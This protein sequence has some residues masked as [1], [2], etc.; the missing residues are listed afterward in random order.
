MTDTSRLH[1][2]FNGQFNEEFRSYTYICAMD[3]GEELTRYKAS[4]LLRDRRVYSKIILKQFLRSAITR[5]PWHGAPWMVKDHL[6]K[7]YNIPTKL[8]DAKTREAIVAAKKAAIADR[9]AVILGPDGGSPPVNFPNAGNYQMNG[10]RPMQGNGQGPN[11]IGLYSG[12]Q[13][14]PHGLAGAPVPIPPYPYTGPANHYVG[15]PP[16]LHDALSHQPPL[17]QNGPLPPHLQQ[18]ANAS[19]LPLPP[20]ASPSSNVAGQVSA[21]IPPHLAQQIPPQGPGGL[22]IS[23]PFQNNF[24]QYQT[25]APPQH[26]QQQHPIPAPRTTFEPVKYPID[27]LRIKQP[28]VN[29]AR[30]ALK[31]FSDDVPEGN[32][33]PDEDNGT[34]ILMNSIGPILTI[35]ET[36]NVHDGVYSLDSFTLDDFVEAMGYSAEEPECELLVEV[37]CAVLKQYVNSSGKLQIQLPNVVEDDESSDEEDDESREATPEPEPPKRTTRSSLRKSE[38]AEI[39][40]KARTPTPEPPKQIH[41]AAEFVAEYD[42][43]EECQERKFRDGGWQ[44]MLVAVLHRLS[45]NP[46]QK[47][48]CDEIL[49]QLV[50]PDE[51]PSIE[52][53]ADNYLNMDVNLR[54]TALDIILRLTVT[55]DEFRELLQTAAQDMTNLRK[56]KIEFQRKRKEL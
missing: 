43:V 5:D 37:H 33:A 24:M 47:E 19:R 6:A 50:P 42:W 54:V 23:L 53:I 34:G 7:R 18:I 48:D 36:L 3:N 32:E 41:K 30:P 25:L 29:V 11:S 39:V 35:W 45:Y 16:H 15:P 51:D 9:A 21:N 10:I 13:P 1:S 2:M 44:A 40:E 52:N 17:V 56:E 49:A 4:E 46:S 22:P 14:Q 38:V 12:G 27:D 55:T 26:L 28:R 20:N 8:P 31:F